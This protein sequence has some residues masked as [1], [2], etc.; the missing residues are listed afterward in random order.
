MQMNTII[1]FGLAA[2]AA[3][4]FSTLSTKA[5][6]PDTFS[7]HGLP[8]PEAYFKNKESLQPTT[9]AASKPGKIVGEQKQKMSKAGKKHMNRVR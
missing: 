6:T 3:G 8:L 9:V 4:A 1:T 2:L 5:N 7:R